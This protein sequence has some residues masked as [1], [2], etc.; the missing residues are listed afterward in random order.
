MILQSFDCEYPKAY[1]AGSPA[2][3]LG[4]F[5]FTQHYDTDDKT[6]S[7]NTSRIRFANVACI[8]IPV[9]NAKHPIV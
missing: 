2:L 6:K 9:P 8:P 7:I 5:I 1:G 3:A 4:F